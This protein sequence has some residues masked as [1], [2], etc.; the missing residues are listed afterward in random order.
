MRWDTTLSVERPLVVA[1]WT[2]HDLGSG[3]SVALRPMTDDTRTP[4]HVHHFGRSDAG[5]PAVVLL[6]GLTEAGTTWP[7]LVEHWGD[8]YRLVAPDLRGHGYSPRFTSAELTR[9]PDVMLADVLDLLDEQ[10]EPVVLLGHSL[11]GNLALRAA[12]TRPDRVRV[13]VLEDPASPGDEPMDEFIAHNEAFLDSMLTAADRVREIERMQRETS[14]SLAELEAWAACK[15]L[16]DRR[17]IREGLWLARMPWEQSFQ[18]LTV[19]TLLVLPNPAPMA[20]RA[21]VVTNPLVNWAVIPDAGHCV[22][23]D[24][25]AAFFAAVEA[26]LE[27]ALR[28]LLYPGE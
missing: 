22:R 2:K 7:A 26:F 19:P 13:L 14:W 28:S 5:A 10:P 9:T 18:E 21:D 8:R 1:R 3:G 27:S 20:P 6:H 15:P 17:Y 16:V 25:P 11:G 23:N 12:L 4:L 24:Q